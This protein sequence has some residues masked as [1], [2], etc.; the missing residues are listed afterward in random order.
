MIILILIAQILFAFLS[1]TTFAAARCACSYALLVLTLEPVA[2]FVHLATFIVVVLLA[3][4]VQLLHPPYQL[5][6]LE[7][8]YQQQDKLRV[9]INLDATV[10]P[11]EC[12][13]FVLALYH[14]GLGVLTA[15]TTSLDGFRARVHNGAW[16]AKWAAL[17]LLLG[18][19]GLTTPTQ[20]DAVSWIV[21][22]GA[23][24]YLL[25]QLVLLLDFVA[26]Q[27]R[28]TAD[29]PWVALSATVLA[30]VGVGVSTAILLLYACAEGKTL[31][32]INILATIACAVVATTPAVQ[33]RRPGLGLLQV[34][35]VALYASYLLLSGALAGAAQ[36]CM[37][38]SAPAASPMGVVGEGYA[39]AVGTIIF[40][41]SVAYSILSTTSAHPPG[42]SLFCPRGGELAP[43][44]SESEDASTPGHGPRLGTSRDV[45]YNYASLHLSACLAALYAGGVLSGWRALHLASSAVAQW[46]VKIACAFV[47]WALYVASICLTAIAG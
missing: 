38:M 4:S 27:T 16:P 34:G 28:A 23:V 36:A 19:A 20:R 17:A 46:Y 11:V 18:A 47:V 3:W 33:S 43:T 9:N 40:A 35:V 22:G 30:Y 2:R 7:E 25:L 37:A 32:V 6:A 8:T 1:C 39:R 44:D 13:C 10:P 41:V 31:A 5:R 26:A 12:L 45:S 29:W 21:L 24:A 14:L 42:S 15:G